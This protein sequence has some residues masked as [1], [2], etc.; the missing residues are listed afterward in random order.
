MFLVSQK[1]VGIYRRGENGR[2]ASNSNREEERKSRIEGTRSLKIPVVRETR[3]R[4]G[5]DE[6]Q[7]S[8]G[9]GL[10]IGV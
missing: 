10:F 7:V 1:I 6:C 8:P 9:V 4:Q 2:R 5:Q 3:R